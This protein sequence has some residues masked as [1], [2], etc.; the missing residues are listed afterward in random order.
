M[1]KIGV[2]IGMFSHTYTCSAAHHNWKA[3]SENHEFLHKTDRFFQ[4]SGRL[5]EDAEYLICTLILFFFKN[6]AAFMHYI[7]VFVAQLWHS[8]ATV[9]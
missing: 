2:V 1:E 6:R 9:A 5:L 3:S 8:C 4:S 7:V